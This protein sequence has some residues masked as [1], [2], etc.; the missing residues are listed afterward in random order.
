MTTRR[1]QR[2]PAPMGVEAEGADRGALRS[3]RGGPRHGKK[4]VYTF[5]PGNLTELLSRSTCCPCYPEINALQSAMRKRSGRVHQRGRALGHSEDVCTYVKCDIGMMKRKGNIGPTG[6]KLPEPDLL[7]LSYTGCFTFMKWFELLK[8]EYNCPVDHAA[9]ALSGGRARS[10]PRC[11]TTWSNSSRKRSSPRSRRSAGKKLDEDRC[12]A[13]RALSA[14]AE[15]DLVHVWRVGQARALAHRRLLRRRLLHRAHLHRLPRHR[16]RRRL[17]PRCCARGRA[18]ACVRARAPSP[19]T[20][21]STDERYRLVVEGPP[22]W[23]NFFDFW[24]MFA[25]EGATSRR[26]HLHPRGRAL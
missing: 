10:P 6:T 17:L 11:A 12:A 7:L 1:A 5:V 24:R 25:D 20:A 21:T 22:N 18:R 9:R 8:Q 19:P 4:V 13:A 16:R 15:D 2:R 14:R 26:E 23:T 3:S